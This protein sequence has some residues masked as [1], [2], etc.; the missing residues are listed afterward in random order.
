MRLRLSEKHG[1]NPSVDKCFYCGEDRGIV[2]FGRLAGDAEAPRSMVC[3]YVP[4]DRCAAWMT[5][6]VILLSVRAGEQKSNN[7]YRTGCFCVVKDEAITRLFGEHGEAA[8][9]ARFAFVDDLMW[10]RVGLP[11]ENVPEAQSAS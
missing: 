8:L 7:P 3:D 11:R 10:D 4:C 9:K 6:G 2:L 1:V 5:K